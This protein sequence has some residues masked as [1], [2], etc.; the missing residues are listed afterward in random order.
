MKGKLKGILFTT[1][2]SAPAATVACPFCNSKTAVQIRAS[3]FGAGFS[4]TCWQ[5]YRPLSFS[6]SLSF[7][8]TKAARTGHLPN[9]K[10]TYMN[11]KP[12]IAAGT[13]MGIG[14]GGFVDGILFHQI[15]QLHSMLS[16]KLPQDTIVNIKTSMVWDGL[17]HALTWLA[18]A[19]SIRMLW[20][21]AKQ[22]EAPLSGVIFSGALFVGW[23]TFNL[24]EG[25]IDHHLLGI[26]H[27][28]ERLGLSVYDYLFLVSGVV[29]V[30]AGLRLIRSG[31]KEVSKTHA[32]SI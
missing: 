10:Y 17:F 21:A 26:H 13:L 11:T 22:K 18:T 6:P 24:V 8:F 4:I 15:L 20:S 19:V 25:L 16:A 12:L 30:I 27:V 14:M 28:V 5:C 2:I 3:L 23:G 1:L 9:S 7:L 32:T 29:L 31:N